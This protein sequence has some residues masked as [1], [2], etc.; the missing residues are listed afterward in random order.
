MGPS[1]AQVD[2]VRDDEC[3]P[4]L[5]DVVQCGMQGKGKRTRSRTYP[6][7]QSAHQGRQDRGAQSAIFIYLVLDD[8]S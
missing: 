3:I 4:P 7:H 5:S 1:W 6:R 8:V 2:G